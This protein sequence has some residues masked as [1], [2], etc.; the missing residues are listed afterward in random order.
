[1]EREEYAR[2]AAAEDDHWWYQSTRRLTRAFLTPWLRPGMRTLDAG[3]GPGGNGTWLTEFGPVIAADL[4]EDALRFVR[5]ARTPMRPVRSS[6]TA[7]PIANASIDCVLATTVLYTVPDDGAAV[8]EFARVLA[9]GGVVVLIEPAFATLRRAHDAVVHGRRRYRTSALAAM[10]TQN[11]LQ[12]G[13]AT[14]AKSFLAPPAFT[15]GVIERMRS[16]PPRSDL[17]SHGVDSM[18]DPM[19]RQLARIEDRWLTRGRRL[20]FGTSAIVV[21]TKR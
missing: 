18:I 9:P 10:L 20:P 4:S 19:F 13:R 16:A 14:Y 2:I 8:A 12:V 7:L 15:L 21:A 17:E 3:C 5:D 1:M 6:V 11:G